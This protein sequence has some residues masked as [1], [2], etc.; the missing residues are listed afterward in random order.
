MPR[1]SIGTHRYRFCWIA[2]S[3][4]CGLVGEHLVEVGRQRRE[5]HLDHGVGREAPRAVD[6]MLGVGRGGDEVDARVARVE[7]D[8]DELAGVLGDVAALGH[9][10]GDRLADV[11]HVADRQ[12]RRDLQLLAEHGVPGL[13]EAAVEVLPRE[14]GD[15]AGQLPCRGGVEAA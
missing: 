1:V 4:T 2:A 8:L 10:E 5:R 14:H 11:A 9:D 13:A 15:H 3:T 12:R 7:V 6:D